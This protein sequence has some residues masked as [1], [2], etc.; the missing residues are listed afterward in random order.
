MSKMA[1]YGQKMAEREGV[2]GHQG[3][4]RSASGSEPFITGNNVPSS[5]VTTLPTLCR[6]LLKSVNL[7][8]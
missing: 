7:N 6:Q 2:R 4:N 3:I 1:K 8:R 5:A